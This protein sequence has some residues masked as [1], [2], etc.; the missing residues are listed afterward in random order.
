MK[1]SKEQDMAKDLLFT[2][3]LARLTFTCE[4][5]STINCAVNFE[6]NQKFLYMK[7]DTIVRLWA[8]VS[9]TLG[10]TKD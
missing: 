7:L 9:Y 4:A 8:L 1:S 5:I 6:Y 2:S 10:M 3:V